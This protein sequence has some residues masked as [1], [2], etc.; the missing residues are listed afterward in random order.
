[1]TA[2]SEPVFTSRL[3]APDLVISGVTMSSVSDPE[4]SGS[5]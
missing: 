2:D 5:P 4:L 1:M 3:L